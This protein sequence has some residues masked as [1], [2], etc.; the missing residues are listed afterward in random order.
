MHNRWTMV[1]GKQGLKDD[2]VNLSIEE[3]AM[4]ELLTQVYSVERAAG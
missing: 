1:L 4:E 3:K 2:E